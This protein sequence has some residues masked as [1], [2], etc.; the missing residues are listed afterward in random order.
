MKGNDVKIISAILFDLDGVIIDSNAVIT[1]AWVVTAMEYG[2]QLDKEDIDKYIIGASATYT[3][4]HLFAKETE[5]T[6][7][8]IHHKVDKREEQASYVLIKGV[9]DLIVT[10]ARHKIKMGLVTSSWPAKIAN[11]IHQHDLDYF[12]TIV[13]R[14][15]VVNGK[16]NSEPYILAMRNL[17][18]EPGQTLVFEDSI[19]GIRSATDAG[20]LCI[21]VNNPASNIP[22][23]NDFTCVKVSDRPQ[24]PFYS[25]SYGIE[26]MPA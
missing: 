3:L 21:S 18:V 9:R 10:I 26:I 4:D 25:S 5:R 14:N 7:T 23:I 17:C 2:Y 20:A 19:N 8:E 1:N 12:S 13:S 16:P 6:R 22:D 24:Y 11:V 15:D